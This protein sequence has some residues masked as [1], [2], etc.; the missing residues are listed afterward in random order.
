[1]F[2]ILLSE[3]IFIFTTDLWGGLMGGFAS[4]SSTGIPPMRAERDRIAFGVSAITGHHSFY[5]TFAR[6][7]KYYNIVSGLRFT[8]GKQQR[9]M[10]ICTYVIRHYTR[11]FVYDVARRCLRVT[12]IRTIYIRL[13]KTPRRDIVVHFPPPSPISFSVII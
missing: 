1:M 11:L 9:R 8:Y 12:F 5:R 4:T 7:N 3:N 13:E 2:N 10:Y 6:V